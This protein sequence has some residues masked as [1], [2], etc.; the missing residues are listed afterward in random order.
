[1]YWYCLG[2]RKVRLSSRYCS[3]YCLSNLPLGWLGSWWLSSRD[4]SLDSGCRR[5]RCRHRYLV[6]VMVAAS[7]AEVPLP[8]IELVGKIWTYSRLPLAVQLL[9]LLMKR[10]NPSFFYLWMIYAHP[11]FFLIVTSFLLLM[12]LSSVSQISSP[13][14][15]LTC[16]ALNTYAYE[17]G[18]PL[19]MVIYDHHPMYQKKMNVHSVIDS[20]VEYLDQVGALAYEDGTPCCFCCPLSSCCALPCS[21]GLARFASFFLRNFSS[22]SAVASDARLLGVCTSSGR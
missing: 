7:L 9:V 10:R 18:I 17:I 8:L 22:R 6:V 12:I 14:G 19:M 5:C 4:L 3:W 1:M 21:S 20:F 13:Y 2:H 16:G 11:F 15:T